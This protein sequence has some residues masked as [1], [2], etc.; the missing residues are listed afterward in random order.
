LGQIDRSW[1][2]R[3]T[4]MSKSEPP[5]APLY[6]GR[7]QTSIELDDSLVERARQLAGIRTTRALVHEALRILTQV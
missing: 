1:I 7:M 3:T 6:G 4:R 2:R 5:K